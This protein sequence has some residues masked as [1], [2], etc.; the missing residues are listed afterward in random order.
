M[1]CPKS[2]VEALSWVALFH[3]KQRI[4]CNLRKPSSQAQRPL[5]ALGAPWVDTGRGSGITLGGRG[6]GHVRIGRW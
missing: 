3:R 5:G 6:V 1:I 4:M 2:I